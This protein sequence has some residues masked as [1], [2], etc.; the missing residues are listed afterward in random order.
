[1][2]I[3]SLAKIDT[4]VAAINLD[5][6]RKLNWGKNLAL[7][8]IVVDK[9]QLNDWRILA[10]ATKG[11]DMVPQDGKSRG[12]GAPVVIEVA[13]ISGSLGD[14]LQVKDLHVR[15]D[16]IIYKVSD[17]PP[18]APNGAQVYTLTCKVRTLRTAFDTTKK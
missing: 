6:L 15:A 9:T 7:E 16:D 8:F 14:I 17:V 5:V 10:V 2:S 18:I 4:K 11:F 1:M 3:G 13:D 12:D